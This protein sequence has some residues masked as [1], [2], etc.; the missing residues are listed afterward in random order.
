MTELVFKIDDN[1]AARF[2]GISLQKFRG[3]DALA[4]EV[5]LK[6]L[7]SEKELEKLVA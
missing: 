7:L 6:S 1:L 3:D 2:R 4:F 5:A